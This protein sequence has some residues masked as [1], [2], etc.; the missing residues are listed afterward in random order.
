MNDG[1]LEKIKTRK[2]N[3]VLKKLE[4]FKQREEQAKKEDRRYSG[5]LD[6]TDIADLDDEIIRED[7]KNDGIYS[8][9]LKGQFESAR[10][11]V[12][13]FK[14]EV[15][16]WEDGGRKISNIEFLNWIDNK[17]DLEIMNASNQEDIA[18][19]NT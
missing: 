5:P 8:L 4:E 11:K 12:R 16:S 14:K 19:D 18:K 6:H 1:K 7:E 17:I 2:E 3:I 10:E 15:E 13:V 9:F